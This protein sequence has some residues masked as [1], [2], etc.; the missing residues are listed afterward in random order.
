MED[1]FRVAIHYANDNGYIEYHAVNKQ[2]RVE[3]ANEAKRQEAESFM[4]Q[5]HSM[6]APQ[7][8]L[9]DFQEITVI[10][11]Q[12]VASFKLVLTRLWE[13]TGILVDWSR[14]V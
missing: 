2:I 8:T 5:S 12:D 10:P 9:L 3:L 4:A 13:N 11:N 14:P 7:K 6:A 1:L